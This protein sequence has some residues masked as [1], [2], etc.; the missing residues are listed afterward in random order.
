M[1]ILMYSL[2]SSTFVICFV[3]HMQPVL[4]FL[5]GCHWLLSYG[6]CKFEPHSW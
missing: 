6:S 5:S 2:D 3:S 1:N 4:L